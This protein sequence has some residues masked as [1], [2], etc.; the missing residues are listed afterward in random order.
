MKNNPA[1][2]GG[3]LKSKPTWPNAFECSATSAFFVF[4]TLQIG[5]KGHLMGGRTHGSR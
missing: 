5:I 2:P 3:S 4:R 1:L